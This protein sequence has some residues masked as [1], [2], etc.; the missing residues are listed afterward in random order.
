MFSLIKRGRQSIRN[1]LLNMQT[2]KFCVKNVAQC[3]MMLLS[4]VGI[5]CNEMQYCFF[6]QWGHKFDS[7]NPNLWV[8]DVQMIFLK[9]ATHIACL[10]I[11]VSWLE[12]SVWSCQ[13]L[14]VGG[15]PAEEQREAWLASQSTFS[16]PRGTILWC[17]FILLKRIYPVLLQMHENSN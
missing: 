13:Q 15:R 1:C 4:K 5:F 9:A 16:F 6:L 3:E 10:Y 14:P 17:P 7:L 8:H 11:Y 2:F 12:A